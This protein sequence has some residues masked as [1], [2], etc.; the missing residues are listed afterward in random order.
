MSLFTWIRKN[1]FRITKDGRHRT[2]GKSTMQTLAEPKPRGV[3]SLESL[4]EISKVA[5]KSDVVVAYK[6][7]TNTPAKPSVPVIPGAHRAEK[8]IIPPMRQDY[9]LSRSSYTPA[10]LAVA[11]SEVEAAATAMNVAV[12]GTTLPGVFASYEPVQVASDPTTYTSP[13]YDTPISMPADNSSNYS[14]PDTSSSTY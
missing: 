6:N 1:V 11:E 13:V 7:N 9:R 8:K 3:V 4:A 2:D 10:Q 14:M 5:E 12:Y